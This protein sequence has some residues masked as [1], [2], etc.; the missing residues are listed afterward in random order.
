VLEEDVGHGGGVGTDL[1]GV[2]LEGWVGGLLE[3]NGDTGNSVVVGSTLASGEDG[4]VDTSLNVGLLVLSEENETGSGTTEGLVGGGGNDIT[5]LEWRGLLT[6]GNETGD[7]GHVAQQ[8]SALGIGDLAQPSVVPVTGV[9]RTSAN[10]ETGLVKV[11]VGLKL[12]VV[13]DTGGWVDSVW[14]RLE[15]DGRSGDLLLG[16]VVA[17]SQVTSVGET[18]TH[19]TVLGVDEGGERGEA[20]ISRVRKP[21]RYTTSIYSRPPPTLQ[22]DLNDTHLAVDPE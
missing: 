19:D 11:G 5:E 9:S 8:V 18:E 7:V 3:G 12:R 2:G 15:V 17:V 14:E 16:G 4:G 10:E 1:L 6:G 13:D 20:G 21:R 22:S